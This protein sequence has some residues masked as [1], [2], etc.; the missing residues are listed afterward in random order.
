MKTP[1]LQDNAWGIMLGAVG[2]RLRK[3]TSEGRAMNRIA[4]VYLPRIPALACLAALS[5]EA[6]AA[7]AESAVDRYGSN[8]L[9]GIILAGMLVGAYGLIRY[10]GRMEGPLA[11]GTMLTGV[12][13]LPSIAI[14]LGMLVVFERAENADFCGSCHLAM[15]SYV[16]DMQDL[17][18]VSL[19]A[20]HFRNRY[21]PRN[22][23][24]VC[25]TS[26]GLFGT[27]EAKVA[28]MMD[29]GKYYTR[30]FH[31][32][33]RMRTPYRDDD[34]L[35]CHAGSIRW[36]NQHGKAGVELAAGKSNCMTCHGK[37]HPAHILSE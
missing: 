6:R 29:V 23:C 27:V 37:E 14:M 1:N 33:V 5:E 20:I 2:L 4:G 11:W 34:C 12:V 8:V 32:P 7:S 9:L 16:R 31:V 30:T 25:H 19:A 18:S 22:Q 21:I 15:Q 26:F 36:K 24:Y 17:Q 35:K 3:I 28:G 10:K 13:V